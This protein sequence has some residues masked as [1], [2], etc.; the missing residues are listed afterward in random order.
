A[1]FLSAGET[2][3]R[4][5]GPLPVAFLKLQPAS[6]T[7]LLIGA[8][9]TLMGAEYTFTFENLN[10]E[11]G[12]LWSQENAVNR[13]I[14]VNQTVGKFTA[15]LSWNDG[16]Y[17]NRYSWLSGSLA[18]ASAPHSLAFVGMGN[19]SQT[20]FR[21]LATPVQN[22]GAVY[23]LIYAYNNGNWMVQPYFQYTD[24]PTNPKIGVA[25]GASTRGAALLLNRFLGRG[26]S[27]SA[28][29]EYISS[30]GG[31]S[32]RSVNLLFGP[33]SAGWSFTL[34]PTFQYKRLFLR[35]ESSFV[36]AANA[37]P[38]GVFGPA[39]FNRTQSRFLIEAGFLF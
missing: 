2:I 31:A 37:A 8:L 13:G 7:S 26:F 21:T 39:G 10:V 11:R 38:S 19:L 28:R 24:V 14:Q 3:N 20:A 30:S 9:P 12:L 27:L 17:S 6:N 32:P 15:A 23:A 22:N 34:T 25:H 16:F 18:Y 33:G 5:Y 36:R 1:P 4:L 29:L 35:A